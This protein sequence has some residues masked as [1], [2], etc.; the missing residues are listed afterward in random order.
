MSSSLPAGHLQPQFSRINSVRPALDRFAH[1]ASALR[2]LSEL[3]APTDELASAARDDLAMLLSLL[4]EPLQRQRSEL[5]DGAS[6]RAAVIDL[7]GCRQEL[8]NVTRRDLRDLLGVL[9]HLQMEAVTAL[10]ND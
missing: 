4:E 9:A 6:A 8:G 1:V 3:L 10:T 5:H 2:A 7:I